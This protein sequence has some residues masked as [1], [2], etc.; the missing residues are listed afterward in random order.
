LRNLQGRRR[1]L[2][3]KSDDRRGSLAPLADD[4]QNESPERIDR[5]GYR[6]DRCDIVGD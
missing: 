1:A 4:L 3:G 5:N 2:R 6:A